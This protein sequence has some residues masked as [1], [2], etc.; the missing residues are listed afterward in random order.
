MKQNL[1]IL[2]VLVAA[3]TWGSG[4]AVAF[5][6]PNVLSVDVA[7][8]G[9][10]EANE[11]NPGGYAVVGG[12]RKKVTFSGT[13][14]AS[15]P[16]PKVRV[17]WVTGKM[18]LQEATGAAV[19]P[20]FTLVAGTKINAYKDYTVS[21][22][23]TF[24][25]YVTGL[26]ASA[27]SMDEAVAIEALHNTP[28]GD[29]GRVTVVEV[30]LK[31]RKKA[32]S[33][34]DTQGTRIATGGL[35][36]DIHYADVEIELSPN[37]TLS[38]TVALDVELTSGSGYEPTQNQLWWWPASV[39]KN[40]LLELAGTQY[41]YSNTQSPIH[42]SSGT[43]TQNGTVRSS[44][45][46]ESTEVKVNFLGAEFRQSIEFATGDFELTLPET[47]EPYEW[48]TMSCKRSLDGVPLQG[49]EV[50]FY[51]ETI[52][53]CDGTSVS[54]QIGNSQ[55]QSETLELYIWIDQHPTP[56]N[57]NAGEGLFG[58]KTT[59]SNGNAECMVNLQGYLDS[60]EIMVVDKNVAE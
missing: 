35:A 60:Y 5:N 1:A 24:D 27:T 42:I 9:V 14:D 10:S 38:S 48:S 25:M 31:T 3:A 30:A 36:A 34:W 58:N 41:E 6:N 50:M 26:V 51:A 44:N 12:A 39:H 20:D 13:L 37:I 32:T 52:I 19:T 16:N 56:D 54:T 45:K 46:S 29:T 33:S 28:M 49:H 15:A 21:T 59:D 11:E 8:D 43:G 57:W 17:S 53:E 4:F 2:A 40:A 7:I 23:F 18:E 55:A 47:Y 22:P